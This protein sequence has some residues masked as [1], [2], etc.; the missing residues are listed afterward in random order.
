MDLELI[1]Q[2]LAGKIEDGV[3]N[4]GQV[5]V[6]SK[7]ASILEVLKICKEDED[8]KM[9]LLLDIVA[10]DFFEEDP[11]FELVYLLYSTVKKHRLRVKVRVKE[12]EVVPTASGIYKSAN[13]AE[14]EAWDMMGIK[15]KDHPNLKRILMFE[16]FEGHPLRKDYP[17]NKRQ[18]IPVIEE[19]L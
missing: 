5:V 8:L 2:K 16:G 6:A 9:D 3:L 14:R 15:F 13:W 11:R 17:V 1:K 4:R 18:P 12:S 7:V 10:V 19:T